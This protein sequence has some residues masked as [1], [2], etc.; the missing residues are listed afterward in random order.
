MINNILA[1]IRENTQQQKLDANTVAFISEKLHIS[2]NEVATLLKN[3]VSKELLIKVDQRPILYLDKSLLEKQYGV[4]ITETSY[5]SLDILLSQCRKEKKDFDKLIGY[6]GSLSNLVKQCKA[7]IAYPPDGLPMMLY[8]PTGTGKSFIAKLAWEYARNHNLLKDGGRFVAVNCSEYA[9]NPELLTANLFGYAKGAFTGA[10]KDKAGLI[11]I[12]DGGVLFLDEVHNLKAECQEKLFQFIDQS[13]YHRLGDNETWYTSKVRLILA[14][15]ESPEKVLLKTLQRRI[16]MT[17]TVP[18]LKERGLQEKVQL[19]YS[20]FQEEEKRLQRKIKISTIVYNIL[21][22]YE[23]P[24][25]I[26]GLKSCVQSCCINSLFQ[27]NEKDDMLIQLSSLPESILQNVMKKTLVNTVSQGYIGIDEL[28]S[29]IHKDK[30]II[31]LNKELL[32]Q[33][34]LYEEHEQKEDVFLNN[35]HKAVWNYFDNLLLQKQAYHQKEFYQNGVR[36]IFDLVSGQY[37]L[38]VKNNDIL[39]IGNYLND[40]T[41]DYHSFQNYSQQN[42]KIIDRYYAF[43][44]EKYHREY[45]IAE[46]IARYL[47]SYLD[48]DILPMA[49]VTFILYFRSMDKEEIFQKRAGVI[50][51][52]GFSTASSIADAVNKFLG[53]YVFDAID[54]PVNVEMSSVLEQ[55]NAYLKKIGKTEELFLLVDMGSLEE[56]YQGIHL[57]DVNIGIINNISTKAALE[58]GNGILQNRAMEDIFKDVISNGTTSYHIERNRQKEKVILCSCASGLGTAEK[59]KQI[60]EDSLPIASKILVKSYDYNELVEKGMNSTLFDDFCVLCVIGTLNPNIDRIHFIPIE[61]LIIND[62]LDELDNLLTEVMEQQQLQQFK[63][64]ILKNFSLSNIMNSLTILNPNKLLEHV[65]D[66]IDRLQKVLNLKLT[67]NTCFGLYVHI[68]CMIER[69]V[70]H[71]GIETYPDLKHFIEIHGDFIESV[72]KTF[73]EVETFYGVSIPDSEVGYIY[74]YIKNDGSNF[75]EGIDDF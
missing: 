61:D 48:V 28:Q 7:T 70:M 46:E 15:T 39:S 33:F 31:R 49:M 44:K 27:E 13:I 54:M 59:I 63:K 32:K 50:L 53:K 26:G 73:K 34:I 45:C 22:S 23:F 40:Y 29:F 52:H 6:D 74:D 60:I 11:E 17:I 75:G 1:V 69:L 66:A 20:L 5:K 8:G 4:K 12:A 64:N 14:T 3:M 35:S 68:S 62:C 72:K 38:E 41:R 55:L 65:A 21:M 47:V 2:R 25:N 9:N 56:I 19:L 51:A 18:S 57:D 42:K 10:E 36:H 58:I 24:G 37:K 67:N 16:P 43:I 71:R 30:E